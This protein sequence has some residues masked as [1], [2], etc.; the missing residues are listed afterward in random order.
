[1]DLSSWIIRSIFVWFGVVL[2]SLNTWMKKVNEVVLNSNVDWFRFRLCSYNLPDFHMFTL[3]SYIYNDVVSN[4]PDSLRLLNVLKMKMILWKF[5]VAQLPPKW[6][7]CISE[8]LSVTWKWSTIWMVDLAHVQ[9]EMSTAL[10]YD[11]KH[12]LVQTHIN[13]I[14]CFSLWYTNQ[15]YI[16]HFTKLVIWVKRL[17]SRS[18]SYRLHKRINF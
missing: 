13:V 11:G 4:I 8:A 15:T 12:T 6:D 5:S 3:S 2:C 16:T 7:F 17:S 10:Y 14:R 1:M 9:F 18:H